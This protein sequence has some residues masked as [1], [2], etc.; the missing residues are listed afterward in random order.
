MFKIW[1]SPLIMYI[2]KHTQINSSIINMYYIESILFTHFY[3]QTNKNQCEHLTEWQI[4]W[5]IYDEQNSELQLY[6]LQC[7]CCYYYCCR[8]SENGTYS[9]P[10]NGHKMT[11]VDAL[12]RYLLRLC[13]FSLTMACWE[14]CLVNASL[15]KWQP[16][17]GCLHRQHF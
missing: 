11:A 13:V 15:F 14:V 12:Y 9:A 16:S 4:F 17:S 6:H 10:H 3:A 2:W 5:H 7:D 8:W 1:L